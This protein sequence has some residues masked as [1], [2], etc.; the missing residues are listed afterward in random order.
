MR[1][2]RRNVGQRKLQ[3]LGEQ[4][5]TAWHVAYGHSMRD[6]ALL[7]PAAEP[8]LVNGTPTL[9]KKIEKAL[10]RSVNRVQWS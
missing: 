9:C 8:V 1:P 4:G 10:G 3:S 2:R 5:V 6:I 7:K